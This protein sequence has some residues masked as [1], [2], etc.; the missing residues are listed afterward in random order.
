MNPPWWKSHKLFIV[1]W[2]IVGMVLL[3][4][5]WM[6]GNTGVALGS[7][8]GAAYPRPSSGGMPAPADMAPCE[9]DLKSYHDPGDGTLTGAV[10]AEEKGRRLVVELALYSDGRQGFRTADPPVWL[11]RCVRGTWRR[12]AKRQER[13]P[14]RSVRVEDGMT[15][16][17]Y[18]VTVPV[19][20]VRAALRT[21]ALRFRGSY[22]AP[23]DA[24]PRHLA[25]SPCVCKH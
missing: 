21:S 9:N 19:A 25:L 17:R 14:P 23:G 20:T 11:E 7:T 12:F 24:S 10:T 1:L 15:V 13:R 2:V 3:T 8:G 22:T 18:R 4:V 5:L 6:T 16:T